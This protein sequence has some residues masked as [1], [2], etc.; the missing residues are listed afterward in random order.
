MPV[1]VMMSS[2]RAGGWRGC[3]RPPTGATSRRGPSWSRPRWWSLPTYLPTYLAGKQLYLLRDIVLLM[4]V[5]GLAA[6]LLD[7]AVAAV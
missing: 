7:P 1:S 2:G 5:A 4:L 6:T 3:S